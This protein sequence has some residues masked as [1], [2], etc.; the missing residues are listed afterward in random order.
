MY[1]QAFCSETDANIRPLLLIRSSKEGNL[2]GFKSDV[3]KNQHSEFLGILAVAEY[4][5]PFGK[6]LFKSK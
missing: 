1:R 4:Y 3:N 6:N 2:S 5:L